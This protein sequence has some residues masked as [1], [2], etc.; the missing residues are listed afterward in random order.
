MIDESTNIS[1]TCH[2]VVFAIFVE[3]IIPITIF[4]GLLE[5]YGS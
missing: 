2:V 3:E 1:V 5:I 4:W